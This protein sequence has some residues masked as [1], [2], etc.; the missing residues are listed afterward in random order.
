MLTS[1]TEEQQNIRNTAFCGKQITSL[2]LGNQFVV[3]MKTSV[4]YHCYKLSIS[5][6]LYYEVSDVYDSDKN[7]IP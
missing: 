6:T 4:S 3:A 7:R 5:K 2:A 1:T